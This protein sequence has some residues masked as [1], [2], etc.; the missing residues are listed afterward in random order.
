MKKL[1]LA[2]SDVSASACLGIDLGTTNCAVSVLNRGKI[3]KVLPIGKDGTTTVPSCVL[4][5]GDNIIVGADAYKVRYKSNCIYS[6]KRLM[7]SGKTVTIT[8]N[9]KEME[10]TPAYVSSCILRYLAERAADV[11]MPIRKCVITVPAYFDQRQIEDTLEAA[12]LADLECIHILKEPT[13]AAYVYSQMGNTSSGDI[14]VYDLGGG[15][16]DVTHLT[17]VRKDA[18]PSKMFTA[19]KRM[20]GI[21]PPAQDDDSKYMCRVL[22]TYGDTMLGGDDIDLLAAKICAGDIK[23]SEEGFQQLVLKV[24]QTKKNGFIGLNLNIE[25]HDITITKDAINRATTE[26]YLRTRKIMDEIDTS[27]IKSIILVGGSTK[28]ELIRKL[29]AE[30]F[31][32]AEISTALNPD[33]TV[34]QGAGVLGADLLEEGH[35]QFQD[36]LPM[37]IGVLVNYDMV[38][39]CLQKNTSIPYSITR[40]FNTMKEG[41]T[42]VSI[43][44]YQ[45]VSHNPEECTYLGTV[46]ITDIPPKENGLSTVEVTFTINLKGRLDITAT[47]EGVAVPVTFTVENIFSVDSTAKATTTSTSDFVCQDDF[48]EMFYDTFIRTNNTKGIELLKKRHTLS[49]QSEIE[50][51]EDEIAM[52]L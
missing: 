30:D 41:Q 20:Y 25:G 37:P 12:K 10:L 35:L 38:E 33:E 21:E 44:V 27:S 18:I 52:L 22:G 13:S 49:D 48:D 28:S 14:L 46:R 40:M 5:E 17:L 36:V 16:F 29:L 23:L 51:I 31:P 19:L 43:H 6:I 7:G 2:G 8:N 15:T 3:P 39:F 11:F 42:T 34:S 9:G 32:K 26:I 45:G 50:A 47:A 4:F 24:E 1:N